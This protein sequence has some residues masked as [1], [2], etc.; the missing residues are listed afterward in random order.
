MLF[1]SSPHHSFHFFVFVFEFEIL[2]V[3]LTFNLNTQ[4]GEH[5]PSLLKDYS[6]PHLF[7]EDLFDILDMD[8]RPSYRWLIIGPQR[9]G[10]S[11]HV[12]PALTSAW[13]TLLSGRK[14]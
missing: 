4:F 1:S 14:R 13:N 2:G 12:D 6:V 8:K 7:Q 5:A 9:S 11:W 10:A 3:L